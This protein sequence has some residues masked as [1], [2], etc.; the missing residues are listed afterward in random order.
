VWDKS[1]QM[2]SPACR[3]SSGSSGSI[4][5][6]GLTNGEGRVVHEV[7]PIRCGVGSPVTNGSSAGS[8]NPHLYLYPERT[9]ARTVRFEPSVLG[10]IL[11]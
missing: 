10:E 3:G 4:V 2:G 8:G 6:T 7:V 11:A 9:E 1:G 5:S